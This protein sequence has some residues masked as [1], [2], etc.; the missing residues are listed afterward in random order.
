[1]H[2][3]KALPS[4]NPLNA[5]DV[6]QIVAWFNQKDIVYVQLGANIGAWSFSW[7]IVHFSTLKSSTTDVQ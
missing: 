5:D 2:R 7:Q 4:S 6:V 1:M 3:A